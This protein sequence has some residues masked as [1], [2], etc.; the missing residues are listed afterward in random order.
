MFKELNMSNETNT[1]N[2]MSSG[3]FVEWGA[4]FGGAVL[5]LAISAVFLQFGSAIGLSM[6]S[7]YRHEELTAGGVLAIGIWLLWVQNTASL[8]GGYL[9]GRMRRPVSFRSSHER[10]M[11]DGI[12]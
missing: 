1:L 6:H 5:A 10:E 3:S 11:R 2:G 8:A 7:P 4:I 12:H 9:A